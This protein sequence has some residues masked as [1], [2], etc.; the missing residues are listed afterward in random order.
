[1]ELAQLDDHPSTV[2]SGGNT[3]LYLKYKTTLEPVEKVRGWLL[4]AAW[5]T[6]ASGKLWVDLIS[7]RLIP[8]LGLSY[9]PHN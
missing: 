3:R 5:K 2:G 7:M 1:M 8:H 4:G 6:L 9:W